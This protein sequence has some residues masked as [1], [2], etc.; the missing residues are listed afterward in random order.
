M[1]HANIWHMR[2]AERDLLVDTGLGISPSCPWLPAGD[3]PDSLVV[4][5]HDHLDHM[6]GAYEFAGCWAHPR[7]DVADPSPGSLHGP[8]LASQPT[9]GTTT[10]APPGRTIA[11]GR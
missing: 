4:L 5:T 6:G 8:T 10:V 7:A 2:G 1:I 9:P 3:S 11:H